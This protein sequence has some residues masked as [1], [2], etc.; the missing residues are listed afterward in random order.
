MD[1]KIIQWN[2]N[3]MHGKLSELRRHIDQE[4]PDVMCIQETKLVHTTPLAMRGYQVFR[5]DRP[6]KKPG[7][8]QNGGGILTLV[9]DGI[10]CHNNTVTTCYLE[11]QS[12]TIKCDDGRDLV[13]INLY[14]P[15]D[16]VELATYQRVA[17]DIDLINKRNAIVMGD[18]NSHNTLWGSKHTDIKGDIVEQWAD[19]NLLCVIN[20]GSITHP[21]G[22]A[23]SAIDLTFCSGAIAA[24]TTWETVP[25]DGYTMSSDHKPIYINVQVKPVKS[26]KYV[27][28]KY[29]L[30][31]ANWTKYT[32][33]LMEMGTSSLYDDDINIYNDNIITNIITAANESIPKTIG[34]VAKRVMVPWWT[35]ECDEAI[36]LRDRAH[37]KSRK[38]NATEQQI[39]DYKAKRAHTFKVIKL[40][41]QATWSKFID[42]IN[43][44]TK[45]KTIWDKI[46]RIKGRTFTPV[47]ILNKLAVSDKQKANLLATTYAEINHPNNYEPEFVVNKLE[48]EAKGHKLDDPGPTHS[49]LSLPFTLVEM[50][51][52][53]Q[54]KKPT[55]PGEDQ[56]NYDMLKYLDA[57]H[58]IALHQY[59]NHIWSQGVMPTAWKHATVIPI[60]KP[61]KPKDLPTSYRPISLTSALCKLHETMVANRIK[62]YLEHNQLLQ[63]DQSGFRSNRCTMDQILRL[64]SDIKKAFFNKQQLGA[65]F[66]DLEKAFDL[67]WTEGLLFKLKRIGITG[68]AYVFIKNF[69]TDRKI[70]VRVGNSTS[71]TQDLLTGTPQGSVLS[72]ILFTILF[73]DLSEV[74]KRTGCKLG[75]YAD[76]GAIWKSSKDSTKLQYDLQGALDALVKWSRTWG[77]KISS[78]KTVA[79]LFHRCAPSKEVIQLSINKVP[80]VFKTEAKLLG[81]WFDQYLTWGYHIDQ[82]VQRLKVDCNLLRCL[83]GTDFGAD[84]QSLLRIFTSLIQS[85]IDYGSQAYH[86][87]SKT[88]LAKLDVLQNRALRIVTGA[89]LSTNTRALA[90]EAGV[91]PLHLRR[92]GLILHYGARTH[93]LGLHLLVNKC[94]SD[95]TLKQQAMARS[96]KPGHANFSISYATQSLSLR[97][98][99]GIAGMEINTFQY[100]P[101]PPWQRCPLDISTELSTLIKK[102]DFP[103]VITAM[104]RELIDRKWSH[105]LQVYTDGSKDPDTGR[106][107]CAIYIPP[108]NGAVY[109]YRLTSHTSVFT[110]EL[111]AIQLA[112][113]LLEREIAV[114]EFPVHDFVILTD[115]L[116]SLQSLRSQ[117]SCRPDIADAIYTANKRL[118]ENGTHVY[119]EWIP[120]HAS[121]T[122][123]DHADLA[124][125]SALLHL[126]VD[127]NT[128]LSYKEI[129]SVIK[130]K[131]RERWN[132][133][134]SRENTMRFHIDPQITSTLR[135]YHRT[136]IGDKIITRLRLGCTRLKGDVHNRTDPNRDKNCHTCGTAEDMT[137]VLIHCPK[138]HD[139]RQNVLS[140]LRYTGAA[141]LSL[142]SLLAPPKYHATVVY[143]AVVKYLWD[144]GLAKSI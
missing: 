129:K 44:N 64:Q 96:T 57:N 37:N 130:N 55:S 50:D 20:D 25:D 94:V 135:S 120:G 105:T 124:A 5:E 75:K 82:L 12:I 77:F 36:K 7:D 74:I 84:K 118:R 66:I 117:N 128:Q 30:G 19:N 139:Q 13:L 100:P 81:M 11:A 144:I 119:Y 112:L 109:K 24:I 53:L 67:V 137:H 48:F 114:S 99:Y 63:D 54:T 127:D 142:Q 38:Q 138:Y 83:T 106:V 71:D 104:S 47:P 34:K 93:K 136:R 68:H 27:P 17:D 98:E 76:D 23:G 107:A 40:A 52:A 102:S 45:S 113:E 87:A 10:N 111:K 80:V 73:D 60:H 46:K 86:T 132:S 140:A 134:W 133:D 110:S 22:E 6:L 49:Y 91:T 59:F 70:Q 28:K 78:E 16:K 31:E 141:D 29:K 1:L 69:L 62:Y 123:N 108:P 35:K 9:R 95:T 121:I 15:G 90:A 14:N 88:A 126:E 39:A 122:G 8:T 97:N 116:S 18:F 2:A 79:M 41:K 65:V 115:S 125:K 101:S 131:T 26:S 92:E 4:S 42:G 58:R 43:I 61:G 33:K 32:T 103:H 21:H 51:I 72:P 89:R 85:K 56:V 143:D 3:G